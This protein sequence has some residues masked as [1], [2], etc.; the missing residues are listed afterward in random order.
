M[1]PGYIDRW[2]IAAMRSHNKPT[3]E[4]G[5]T[6][7]FHGNHPGTHAL[8]VKHSA[9]VRTNILDAFTGIHDCSVGGHVLDFFPRMGQSHFCLVPRG[10]S[11]WTIHLYESFF[12]GC[13]PVILSDQFD[14]PFQE[15]VDWPS[16]SIKWPMDKIDMSLLEYLRAIPK[17]QVA[18]MKDN[19]ERNA[20]WFD[21][22]NGWTPPIAS[23]RYYDP[24]RSNKGGSWT[25]RAT[26]AVVLEMEECPYLQHGDGNDFSTCQR[27]CEEL[28]GPKNDGCNIVNFRPGE[29]ILRRCVD[30]R[31]PPLTTLEDFEVWSL[32]RDSDGSKDREPCSPFAAVLQS[33]EHR[34]RN[35]PKTHGLY[36]MAK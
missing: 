2:R 31:Q 26:D 23:S 14:L 34:S 4:R 11:A 29:C 16:F 24:S 15:I 27:S 10:S 18:R 36:W 6:I 32:Q 19:L 33:L 1:I 28:R 13:I 25:L 7:I 8:Y 20:C 21:Y 12:F 22:H 5:Y 9:V 17:D 30:V 3:M 35:I